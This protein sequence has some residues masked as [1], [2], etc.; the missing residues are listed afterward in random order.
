MIA[1]KYL[2]DHSQCI[3][4]CRVTPNCVAVNYFQLSEFK[5][6]FNLTI[7]FNHLKIYSFYFRQKIF[8]DY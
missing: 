3:N 4:L 8:V 5:V 6:K 2:R 7:H 1:S